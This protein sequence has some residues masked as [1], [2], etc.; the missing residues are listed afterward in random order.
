VNLSGR[1]DYAVEEEYGAYQAD[2]D[3][4][5]HQSRM[6]KFP[7][8]ERAAIAAEVGSAFESLDK[9]PESLRYLQVAVRLEPSA[10][11][12]AL[13]EKQIADL[14]ARIRRQQQNEARRPIIHPALEQDRVVRP[15]LVARSAPPPAAGKAR[16]T[17]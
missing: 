9:L 6:Q 2:I 14:R 5:S 3:V 7:P 16:R 8:E 11:K 10:Q 13:L 1:S 4:S 17:P 15:M 12:K